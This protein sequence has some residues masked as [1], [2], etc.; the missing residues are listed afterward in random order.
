ML[1]VEVT[2]CFVQKPWFSMIVLQSVTFVLK[3]VSLKTVDW[4]LPPKESTS[5]VGMYIDELYEKKKKKNNIRTQARVI[6]ATCK[7]HSIKKQQIV[8]RLL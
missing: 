1:L 7:T 4:L 3:V 5:S 8:L 6:C 2:N